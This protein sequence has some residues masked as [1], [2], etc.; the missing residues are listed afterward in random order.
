MT[1]S[2]NLAMLAS[3]K[4]TIDCVRAFGETDFRGDM[5]HFKIPTLIIHGD[6]DQTVPFEISGKVAAEMIKG[7]RLMVYE[8]APH[9]I[10]FTHAGQLTKDLLGFLKA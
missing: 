10:P 4:A 5:A 3:P 6:G 2:G 8:G 9:A 1:W 7:S